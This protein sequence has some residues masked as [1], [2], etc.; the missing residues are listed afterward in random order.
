MSIDVSVISLD[1]TRSLT[2]LKKL[3]PHDNVQVQQGIDVRDT[4]I[5]NMYNAGLIG[6]AGYN[7]LTEGRKWHSELNSEGCV[8]LAIANRLAMEKGTAPLL[9][10]EDDFNIRNEHNF[11]KDMAI[12]RQNMTK[13]DMA[14][15]GA[16]FHGDAKQLKSVK[17]MPK[18][19]FH[20]SHN[21]IWL[22]H[23]AFYTP[24]GRKKIGN[25]LRE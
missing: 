24:N 11:V 7:S 5:D 10:L 4:H 25:L 13:F 14:V 16:V 1:P 18:G 23:C 21:K 12:L 22:L 3:F 19:W 8:G 6:V 20:L 9:L 17:F 15:F 2:K